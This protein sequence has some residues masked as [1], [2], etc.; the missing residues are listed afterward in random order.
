M[1]MS[2]V[3]GRH[4][5]ATLV[6]IPLGFCVASFVPQAT[7]LDRYDLRSEPAARL[8]LPSDLRE[9]SGL[10]VSADGSVFAHDD[11][12]AEIHV[13]DA[14]TG[15]GLR[16]FGPGRN[17]IEGDFEGLATVDER[18]FIIVSD[19]TIL[20]FPV[21]A[22]EGV[23]TQY[24]RHATGLGRVCEI[25]GLA[26]DARSEE[27]L[28]ACKSM[29]KGGPPGIYAFNP[30]TGQLD[31]RPRFAV[32]LPSG[33]EVSPS[34]LAIHPA[35]GHLILVAARENLVVEL[36]RQGTVIATQE[37]DGRNHLQAEG[38]EF[39]PDGSLIISDEGGGHRRPSYIAVYA[40]AGRE[41]S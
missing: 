33:D 15:K 13:I 23:R 32:R 4:T 41:P 31:P 8:A 18:L 34:G 5:S 36:D 2:R 21:G 9:I 39:L 12:S 6:L 35:T 25:E 24:R 30:R 14:A 17:V 37:L 10:A 7:V 27:L 38:I 19:G 29:H 11:E 20:E 1:R 26:Y 40:P 3:I 22:V 16:S 28:A